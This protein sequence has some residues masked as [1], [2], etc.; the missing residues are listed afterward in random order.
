MNDF[1]VKDIPSE[2][3]ILADDATSSPFLIVQDDTTKAT[4][5]A[6]AQVASDHGLALR[7]APPEGIDE[8]HTMAMAKL[9]ALRA[10]ANAAQKPKVD[11][12]HNDL[13]AYM[14]DTRDRAKARV[15]R[16]PLRQVVAPH[17]K[18]A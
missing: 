2:T 13:A 12:A 10:S 9:H 6:M 7:Q 3:H 1:F 4:I 15:P 8:T 14:A 5:Q 11:A 18:T 16:T 17:L